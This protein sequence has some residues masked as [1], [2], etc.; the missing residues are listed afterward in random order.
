ME[1]VIEDYLRGKVGFSVPD[2]ALETIFADRGITK[3]DP[4]WVFDKKTLDLATADLY[5]YCASTPSVKGSTEDSHGGWK[6]KDGG[7]ES[8]AYDKR[9]LRQMA[10]EI[11]A[12]YGEKT[13]SKTGTFKFI[14]L[15]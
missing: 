6:H 14:Q 4:I 12:Y 10:N 2:N 8:S 11:Y 3:G 1:L 5:M 15:R 7:W 9:N 13:N